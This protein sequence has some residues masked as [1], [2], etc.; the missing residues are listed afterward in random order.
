MISLRTAL[1]AAFIL[2]AS[3]QYATARPP[4]P[5]ECCFEYVTGAI[6][7]NKLVDF[8]WTPSE[9]HLQAAVLETVANRKVCAD[10]S[11]PWVKRAIRLL[12]AKRKQTPLSEN[13]R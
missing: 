3:Y 11:K 7:F 8:Y 9:C 13:H 12:Q 10:P 4:S 5:V 1:L 2:G 6:Q